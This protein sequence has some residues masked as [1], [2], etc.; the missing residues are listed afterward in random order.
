MAFGDLLLTI[1][2][3]GRDNLAILDAATGHLLK[4]FRGRRYTDTADIHTNNR[5]FVIH[6]FNGGV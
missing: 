2:R 6:C 1:G 3:E 4:N 5:S